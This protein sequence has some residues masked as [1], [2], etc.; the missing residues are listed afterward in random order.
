MQNRNRKKLKGEQGKEV[1]IELIW[2]CSCAFHIYINLISSAAGISREKKTL[3]L[4]NQRFYSLIINKK[5]LCMP[6]YSSP[7]FLLRF[8]PSN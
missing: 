8:P 1:N 5:N 3:K 2:S 7:F 4:E 6:L